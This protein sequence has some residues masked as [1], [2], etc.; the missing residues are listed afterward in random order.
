MLL[1]ITGPH[2]VGKTTFMQR[3][4][5]RIKKL[6]TNP[7]LQ[8]VVLVMT[9]NAIEWSTTKSGVHNEDWK[10]TQEH[11]QPLLE[12]AIAD[13]GHLYI[14]ETARAFG[15]MYPVIVR[16]FQDCH[17]GAR[18][19]IPVTSGVNLGWFMRQRNMINGTDF[20]TAYWDT[21][22]LNYEAYGRYVNQA[23]KWFDPVGLIWAEFNLD[24]QRTLW[25]EIENTVWRL[26]SMPPKDWYSD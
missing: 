25:H 6:P 22:R 21:H 12:N 14:V 4:Q 3:L 8:R 15:G 24:R 5:Q 19:I 23:H 9:D 11:K 16:A 18:F 7:A 1:G 26:I 2:A 13:D 17:G 20:N 10:R